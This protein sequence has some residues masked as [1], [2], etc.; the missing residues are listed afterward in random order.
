MLQSV[1][2]KNATS[3]NVPGDCPD[4]QAKCFNGVALDG[5]ERLGG[6]PAE[7]AQQWHVA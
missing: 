2:Q 1:P 6:V 4:G 7:A 3:G 5:D